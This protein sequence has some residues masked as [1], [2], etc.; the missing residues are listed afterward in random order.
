[1]FEKVSKLNPL[2][3]KSNINGLIAKSEN[4]TSVFGGIKEKLQNINMQIDA[5][6]KVRVTQIANLQNEVNTLR[7]QRTAN[8]SYCTKIDQ[9]S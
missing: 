1:M 2:S 7:A 9:L 8:L 4:A 3:S 6:E 5:E